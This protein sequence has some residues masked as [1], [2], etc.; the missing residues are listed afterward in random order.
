M[1]WNKSALYQQ[2][3]KHGRFKDFPEDIYTETE[4]DY[5]LTM[6]KKMN[7]K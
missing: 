3:L 6:L 4:L 1:D 5:Y 2:F 7:N